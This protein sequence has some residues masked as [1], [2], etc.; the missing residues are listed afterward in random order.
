MDEIQRVDPDMVQIIDDAPTDVKRLIAAHLREH[1]EKTFYVESTQRNMTYAEYFALML[2]DVV[3]EG[4]IL[5]ADGTPMKVDVPQWTSIA[6]FVT[7]HLEGSA[8]QDPTIGNV[9]VFKVYMG[10]D[11]DKV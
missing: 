6:K 9:N 8:S 5:F 4:Q 2:W 10:F 7:T 11:E 1:A 3:T